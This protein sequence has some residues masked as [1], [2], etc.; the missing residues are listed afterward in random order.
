MVNVD[1]LLGEHF[2]KINTKRKRA[3]LRGCERVVGEKGRR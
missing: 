3:L 1:M 2:D